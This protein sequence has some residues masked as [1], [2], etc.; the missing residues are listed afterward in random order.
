VANDDVVHQFDVEEAPG[1]HQPLRGLDVLR[2]GLGVA[3]G[4]VVA[5]DETRAVADDRRAEDLRGAH[6][7]AVDGALVTVSF[8]L[9]NIYKVALHLPL[10]NLP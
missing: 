2:G 8:I 10:S 3:T 9:I 6:D 1:L 4:M 5:E 7:R